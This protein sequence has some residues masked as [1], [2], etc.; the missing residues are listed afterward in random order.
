MPGLIL[1]Q[2]IMKKLTSLNEVLAF[3]LEGMYDA[4]KKLQHAIPLCLEN[5]RLGTL[6]EEIK[7]YGELAAEKR[8]KLKRQ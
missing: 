6:K 7:K 8:T 4:E 2:I 3:Q 5:I 1:N